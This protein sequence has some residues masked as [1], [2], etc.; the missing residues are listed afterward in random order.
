MKG[1]LPEDNRTIQHI[2]HV[3]NTVHDFADDL[4]ESLMDRENLE[5]KRKAQELMKFLAD[6]IQ[7]LSDDI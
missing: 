7:S 6:L 1:V 2:N 3:S 4:Y 5:A